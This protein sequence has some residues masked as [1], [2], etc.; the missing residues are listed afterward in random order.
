MRIL[1]KKEKSIFTIC[2]ILLFVGK[3]LFYIGGFTVSKILI[4]IGVLASTI[5]YII[6]MIIVAKESKVGVII[7][8]L[9]AF[10]EVLLSIILF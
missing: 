10:L 4:T 9:C 7:L 5:F 6:W 2:A 3:I 8:F 1:N